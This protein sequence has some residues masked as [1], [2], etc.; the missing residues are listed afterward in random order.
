MAQTP[1]A[2]NVDGFKDASVAALTPNSAVRHDNQ[3]TS[4][5]AGLFTLP[6]EIRDLVYHKL[7][8]FTAYLRLTA[9]P[10]PGKITY[11][12]IYGAG[13]NDMSTGLPQWLLVNKAII[14]QEGL[15]QL[16][17]HAGWVMGAFRTL[18]PP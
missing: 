12:L 9:R 4:V 17:R 14:L 6:Q 5:T 16:F 10:S 11:S 8:E 18:D 15:C 2:V 13:C 1:P 7:W 3:T